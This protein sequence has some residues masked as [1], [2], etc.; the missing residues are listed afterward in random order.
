MSGW[1]I[2]QTLQQ[3]GNKAYHGTS[4]KL[5]GRFCRHSSRL[6]PLALQVEHAR[7]APEILHTPC[8]A[9]PCQ[10]KLASLLH[11]LGTSSKEQTSSITQNDLVCRISTATTQCLKWSEVKPLYSTVKVNVKCPS[12]VFVCHLYN[13]EPKS[14]SSINCYCWTWQHQN[15]AMRN[16]NTCGRFWKLGVCFRIF[17]YN[18]QCLYDIYIISTNT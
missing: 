16:L 10:R 17:V 13:L 8:Q 5:G 9:F 4:Q 2:S 14:V 18:W 7:F 12:C 15:P 6:L 1:S 11:F 3:F